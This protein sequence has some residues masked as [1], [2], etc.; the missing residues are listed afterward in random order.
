MH[1]F[2][3]TSFY[4]GDISQSHAYD[5]HSLTNS[6]GISLTL[7]IYFVIISSSYCFVAVQDDVISS[8][9]AFS[10]HLESIPLLPHRPLL[11]SH[12]VSTSA[13]VAPSVLLSRTVTNGVMNGESLSANLFETPG[14]ISSLLEMTQNKYYRT[15]LRLTGIFCL[16]SDVDI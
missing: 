12:R 13:A 7:M 15:L 6:R 4:V 2:N 11:I 14:R 9:S 8:V 16:I 3:E 5:T 10:L 1:I